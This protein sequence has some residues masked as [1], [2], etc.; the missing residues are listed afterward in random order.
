MATGHVA[1]GGNLPARGLV[2]KVAAEP[3]PRAHD[4]HVLETRSRG[5]AGEEERRRAPHPALV[6]VRDDDDGSVPLRG[7]NE[8]HDALPYLEE[9][10]AG[11]GERT[12]KP[13][14]VQTCG[15]DD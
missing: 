10:R 4:L 5:A 8:P 9:L 2:G 11:V 13:A 7:L 1:E 14:Q 12:R 15:A 3:L 6:G